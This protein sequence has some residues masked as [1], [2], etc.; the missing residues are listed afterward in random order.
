[1]NCREIQ[2]WLHAYTDGE[3]DLN[4]S[5]DIEQHLQ[6]CTDCTQF[7]KNITVLHTAL[8][9]EE[10][11]HRVPARL[12][13]RVTTEIQR[14]A[15]P[16]NRRIG[17][18]P[19]RA[20]AGIVAVL[21]CIAVLL[22]YRPAVS[23]EGTLTREVIASHIRSLMANHLTDVTSTD[24]H[25]VKPWF[26]GKLDYAPPVV[27]LRDEGFPLLGGRLDYLDQRPVAVLLYGRQKHTIN[28][29]V[30]PLAGRDS[31]RLKS[32]RERTLQGYHIVFWRQ[33]DL[34]FWAVSDLNAEELALFAQRFQAAGGR[35]P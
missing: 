35:T 20:F 1:M 19:A 2:T 12:V 22:F 28:L 10:L 21:V 6:Q 16:R 15:R 14:D 31:S 4:S 26:N 8:Q 24:R 3:L 5:L 18:F 25:T 13:K 33:G 34:Q 27:E 17:L 32:P 29:F 11:Y 9:A 23:E 7:H 30:W